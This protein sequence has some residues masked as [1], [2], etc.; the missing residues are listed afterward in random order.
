MFR[1]FVILAFFIWISYANQMVIA[2][3]TCGSESSSLARTYKET[4]ADWWPSLDLFDFL[5]IKQHLGFSVTL[6]MG[7]LAHGQAYLG[8]ACLMH[9]NCYDGKV[10]PGL[11]R[12]QCDTKLKEAWIDSC[13]H[14]YPADSWVDTI[15]LSKACRSYC[16][17]TMRVMHEVQS[18]IF[19]SVA[20]EAWD[21]S[22][23]TRENNI[24]H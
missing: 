13:Y 1:R 9:D 22:K 10:Y 11:N 23:E 5:V 4:S 18:N 8:D 24:K 19:G 7:C 15:S 12:K 6:A 16:V 17:E 21:K 14:Q 2:G 3:T 20:D